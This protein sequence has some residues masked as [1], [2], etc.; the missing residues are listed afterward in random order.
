MCQWEQSQEL[1][2]FM[3]TIP[4]AYAQFQRPLQIT[5]SITANLHTSHHH[6]QL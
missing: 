6:S 1:L 4:L 3:L 5:A 2:Q